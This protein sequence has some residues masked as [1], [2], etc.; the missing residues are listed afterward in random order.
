MG[1]VGTVARGVP[2][3]SALALSPLFLGISAALIL[4][5]KLET[6]IFIFNLI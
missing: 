4:Q 2:E 1:V 5:E 3:G 6:Y